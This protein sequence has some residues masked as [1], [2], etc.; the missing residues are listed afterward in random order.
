VSDA[1]VGT[2]QPGG[3]LGDIAPTLLP[4]LGLPTPPEMTGTNLLA[5]ARTP[6]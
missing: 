2:L 3:R 5:P 4:L 6:A 1:P